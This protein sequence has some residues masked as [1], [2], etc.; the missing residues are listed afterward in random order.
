MVLANE[1]SS[2]FTLFNTVLKEVYASG[3][4]MALFYKEFPFYGML[5]KVGDLQGRLN[6]IPFHVAVGQGRSGDFQ[7]SKDGASEELFAAWQVQSKQDYAYSTI[8][9]KLLKEANSNQAAFVKYLTTVVDGRVRALTNSIATQLFGTGNGARGA[10]GSSDNAANTIT[11]AKVTD[12]VK[13][14]VNQTIEVRDTAALGTVRLFLTGVESAKITKVDRVTGVLT[15]DANID[16]NKTIVAGDTI[17]VKGDYSATPKLITGLPA[18]L[19]ETVG[20]SDNF[21]GQ[22]R[23]IDRTRLAG[24]YA[25]FSAGT[26]EEALVQGG[27]LISREAAS[28]PDVVLMN[29]DD[30]AKLILEMG[31]KVERSEKAV[32]EFS[33]SSYKVHLPSGPADI[34]ADRLCPT[35]EA[36]MLKMDTW[37]LHHAPGELIELVDEDGNILQRTNDADGFE[38]RA[39]CYSELVCSSPVENGR[40]KLPS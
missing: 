16:G 4:P 33:W 28:S 26:I 21:L 29:D 39:A 5:K 8:S 30:V 9:R 35:G 25:D 12:A 14:E 2:S 20:P 7:A 17:F 32:G 18:W 6:L 10:V 22:N 34:I 24:L 36:Y 27:R 31:S 23:S 40:I 3:L 15:V 11:L 38:V 37:A 1:K 13:F 19:P